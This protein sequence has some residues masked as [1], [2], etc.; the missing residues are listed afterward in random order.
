VRRQETVDRQIANIRQAIV[1]GLEDV[2]WANSELHRLT[3]E[4]EGLE[5]AATRTGK[6]PRID[7]AAVAAYLQRFDRT[8]AKAGPA[9][10]RGL[11][12]ECVDQMRLE[13]AELAVDIWYMPPP[14]AMKTG[15]ESSD[16]AAHRDRR[17]SGGVFRR[18]A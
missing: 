3:Q 6:P 18:N 14:G 16:T 1:N 4:R 12:R 10:V 5:K 11:I 15:C 17:G 7:S 2:K 9:E 13:P 8:L